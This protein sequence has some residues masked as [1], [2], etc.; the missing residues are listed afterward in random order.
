MKSIL[1]VILFWLLTIQ[2]Y[3]QETVQPES[4]QHSWDVFI[5]RQ[6][7]NPALTDVIFID[8]LSGDESTL[9]ASGERFTLT[10]GGVVFLDSAE[11]QV[12]LAKADGII[13]DHPYINLPS[14]AHLVEW[15]VSDDKDLIVW[16]VSR[17]VEDGQLI[18]ATWL[19]DAAGIEIRELL[20][21]GP[22]DGI[23]LLPIGFGQARGEIYMEARV[24]GSEGVSPYSRRT[25]LFALAL[26]KDE[27]VTRALPG[28]QACFCAVGFGS[29]LMM[30]LAPNRESRGLDV[31]IYQLGGGDSKVIPALSRGSYSEGGNI[32]ISADGKHAVY[33]LSRI[34]DG[35]DERDEIRTVLVHVDIEEGRQQIASSPIAGTIQPLAFGEDYRTVLIAVGQREQTLK[36]DLEDGRLVEVADAVYLGQVGDH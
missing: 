29:N 33:A 30:R 34:G 12:K 27:L 13:R 5:K 32:L 2:S 22:R 24:Q 16:S 10:N 8:L 36:A 15:A 25:G 19:A 23:Q 31:E 20:V 26:S 14:E 3:S 21:Y 6:A 18:T 28:D 17:F 7:A 11:R 9:S 1:L 35:A 4:Q